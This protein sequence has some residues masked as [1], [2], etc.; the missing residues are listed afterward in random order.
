MRLAAKWSG[1]LWQAYLRTHIHT[2]T[3]THTCSHTHTHLFTHTHM[4]TSHTHT[5]T[6]IYTYTVSFSVFF[7]CMSLSLSSLSLSSLSLSL[8][9]THTHRGTHTLSWHLWWLTQVF[10]PAQH[11]QGAKRGTV[12]CHT[13]DDGRP[14]RP[15][16]PPALTQVHC[17]TATHIGQKWKAGERRKRTNWQLLTL[18]REETDWLLQHCSDWGLI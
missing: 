10:A 13:A 12:P 7:F 17:G 9:D 3:H 2:H 14:W 5:H 18:M 1:V 4:Y 8:S 16:C 15:S 11:S 6:H